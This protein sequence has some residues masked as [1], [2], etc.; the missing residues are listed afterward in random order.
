MAG[1]PNHDDKGRF[2]SGGGSSP[3]QAKMGNASA[4]VKTSK[5]RRAKEIT[6]STLNAVARGAIVAGA[7]AALIAKVYTSAV[8]KAASVDIQRYHKSKHGQE[9]AASAVEFDTTFEIEAAES[10]TPTFKLS[11]YNGGP[12]TVG[13]YDMPVVVDLA[14]LKNAPEV[15]ANREHNKSAMV[16]HVTEVNNNGRSLNMAGIFS[17]EGPDKERILA[18][19]KAKFP[20]KASI[21]VTPGR[22]EVLAAGKT[23]IVNG[24]KFSGPLYI[25]RDG[26]LHGVAFVPRGADNSTQVTIAAQAAQEV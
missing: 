22:L 24:Q 14:S 25:A 15:L 8:G 21:E 19:H 3:S 18:S 2:A 20:F 7:A 17:Y 13:K 23:A 1:N 12:L 6:K 5:L 16:G 9:M 4:A 11:A 10:V 26:I